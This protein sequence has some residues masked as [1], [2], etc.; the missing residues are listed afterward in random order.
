[1]CPEVIEHSVCGKFLKNPRS[2]KNLGLK[3]SIADF[4]RIAK[5]TTT[6]LSNN[7]KK[8]YFKYPI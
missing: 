8:C 2:L 5:F 7:S 4:E 3:F 6:H 1:M